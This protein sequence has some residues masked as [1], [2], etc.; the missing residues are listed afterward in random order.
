[1]FGHIRN[2]D[3]Q[4][5]APL[6]NVKLTEFKHCPYPR[7][8]R[9]EISEQH[10][11]LQ[12]TIKIAI[13]TH[14][15]FH[16]I[17]GIRFR[18]HCHITSHKLQQ[19]SMIIIGQDNT[20]SVNS[21]RLHL[22]A[23][24]VRKPSSVS[25]ELGSHRI[26]FSSC[27]TISA[28]KFRSEHERM[29]PVERSLPCRIDRIER[30]QTGRGRLGKRTIRHRSDIRHGNTYRLSDY[31]VESQEPATHEIIGNLVFQCIKSSISSAGIVTIR[32]H[33]LISLV[34]PR[35][36]IGTRGIKLIQK[37]RRHARLP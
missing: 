33:R 16:V 11:I 1:M 5:A 31:R 29:D 10:E 21:E 14:Q 8:T 12:E 28:V 9:I 32:K 25:I 22:A 37:F 19:V 6:V 27:N 36:I 23:F 15:F 13:I 35:R 17:D 7:S 26:P 24:L 34:L 2:P 3:A 18:L 30:Q 20:D 4:V